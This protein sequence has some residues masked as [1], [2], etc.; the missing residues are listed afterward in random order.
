MKMLIG[1][2]AGI[3]FMAACAPAERPASDPEAKV[4]NREN[5]KQAL[6]AHL[7]ESDI[8]LTLVTKEFPVVVDHRQLVWDALVKADLLKVR[9]LPENRFEYDLTERGKTYF[10]AP[11]R[12]KKRWPKSTPEKTFARM[13]AQAVDAFVGDQTGFRAAKQRVGEI[14]R[15]T[16]PGFVDGFTA[17]VVSYTKNI[18]DVSPWAT[19]PL[20]LEMFP[21]L[22]QKLDPARVHE[23]T[24]SCRPRPL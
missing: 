7:K 11:V 14:L 23:E 3:L 2:A 8:R 16:K 10:V 18:H 21:R 9:A 20:V 12:I 1:I 24:H 15:F 5:F 17:S 22:G 13:T 4:A 19:D 6:D